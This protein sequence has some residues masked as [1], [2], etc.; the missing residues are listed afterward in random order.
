M[1][2]E[3][4]K[5]ACTR[6]PAFWIAY[7]AFAAIALGLAWRLFPL[8]IPIVNL[9][10]T[11]GRNEAVAKAESLAAKLGLAPQ[12]ARSAARFAHDSSTQ[13]YVELEGGGK[14]AF[15]T[16]V[17]GT[18]YAP[19]WWEVRLFKP[20]DV[21]E[22]TIRFRPDG[23]P[24][25]FSR[26]VPEGYVRDEAT[27]AL[28]AGAA[29]TLAEERSAAEWK[30]DL[31]SYRLLEQSQLTQPAGRVDHTF[32]YERAEQLGEARI[33]LR[34]AVAG[35]ELIGIAPYVHIPESFA[36]RF[37]EL[38]SANDT[39]AGIAGVSAGLLYGLGGCILGAL[40]LARKHWLVVRP[41]LIA[42]LSIGGLMAAAAL[43]ASSAAW[44]GFDTTQSTTT[45]W[46]RAIGAALAVAIAGGLAY[47]LVFMAAE[48]LT[49]RAFAHQPQLWRVWSSEGGATRA[50]LGRTIGGY[51]FVPL[52]LALV[53]AF[54]Y[55]TH[56]WLG[57]WQP[58][59]VLTDPNILSSA[60]PAL[61]PIAV[62]LQ[63]GF[64]EECLFRAIPL[65]LGAL[66]GAHF[67]RRKFGIGIAFVL[68]AVVF[69]AAHANYPGFPAYSRLVEL[70]L[71][72]MLWAAIFLRFGLLPTI[73][74]HAVFDLALFSI[75]LFLID[76]PEAWVQRAAV[77]AAG[78]VPLA[79][80]LWRRSQTTAWGELPQSLLNRAW[81][82][83]ANIPIRVPQAGVM[84]A[85]RAENLIQRWLPWLGIGGAIAWIA[86]TPM[87]ADVPP[88][89]LDRAAA[90]AAA[91]AAL[92]ARGVIL[93]PEWRR[94]S[95]VRRG[96]EG[97][98]WIQHTFVW[99]EAGPAAYRALVG[100]TLTPPLWEVRY[101]MFDGDIAARAEEWRVTVE[102]GGNARQVRH[103][104]P[105]AR[106]GPRLAKDVALG[107]AEQHLRERFQMDPAVV[108]LVAA[109]E[110]DR[111]QRTDWSFMFGDKRIDVGKDGEARLAVSVAGDEIVGSGRFIHV[112]EAW[113]RSERQRA[114]RVQNATMVGGLLFVLASLAAL[115]AGVK[116]WLRRES[117]NRALALVMAIVFGAS[118]A[119]IALRWPALALQLKT[120]EP[121]AWQVMLIVSGLLL[122]A[123]FG[124]L[125]VGLAAGVGAWAA[126]TAPRIPL[127]G[128]LPPWAAGA[129]AALFV[130]GAAALAGSL[131]PSEAP[132]WPSFSVESAAFPWAAAALGGLSTLSSIAVG[133]FVLHTLD[134]VT[135]AWTRRAW[136]AVVAI[137]ALF[138]VLLAVKA[139]ELGS[140]V[141]AGIVA[142]LLAAAIVYSVLRFDARTVPGYMVVTGLVHAAENAAL[143]GTTAAWTAFAF[144]AA[145]SIVVGVAA[146]RY[147]D[148]PLLPRD[149]AP[150]FDSAE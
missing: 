100:A 148:R 134:R 77:I 83:P 136:V 102:P 119:G 149:A 41:A 124:A 97:Q 60:V 52:E 109:E 14:A 47:T 117:D 85:S 122:A 95:A 34:L 25:G 59:E 2:D 56:R 116:S 69:G 130:A 139:G 35:D 90:E 74:L 49:R 70:V 137:V 33:R 73:L 43:S 86:F 104:L 39:I 112:P 145:T 120:T 125:V 96:S 12:D 5:P 53:A 113:L 24:D 81:A 10:V 150:A 17:M 21:N 42:G 146:T 84:V 37:R 30:L 68:Q 127:V 54:Y 80:I 67:G 3:F 132:L 36:R 126:R 58:S 55:A 20:G 147:L 1:I 111:P 27:K 62:S 91:D 19:Y 87:H 115:V 142:G 135:A 51:L 129:A 105:E 103:V 143:L 16:L 89:P 110:T 45:F 114:G 140:A 50:V 138:T 63:A 23:A 31:T 6:R 71:P 44:F 121:I 28:P 32:V 26:R 15:G 29:R 108:S 98:Q 72:S 118:A 38:R 99:R 106:Q 94:L 88:L 7:G 76:T 65:A 22:V 141:A 61:M 18:L 133:I 4:A 92:K 11:L 46:L 40:W 93:G 79:V 128:S 107:L 57:W 13:N 78:L 101:A 82:P 8:A 75:P 48:S 64:M 66:I 131:T 123:A 144:S 9:D